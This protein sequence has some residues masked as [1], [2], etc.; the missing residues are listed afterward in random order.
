MT[1]IEMRWGR[2]SGAGCGVCTLFCC[3]SSTTASVD[4]R[5]ISV[6]IPHGFVVTIS[7]NRWS[8]IVGYDSLV[9][10]KF[11]RRSRNFGFGVYTTGSWKERDTIFRLT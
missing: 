5:K 8:Q 3:W 7:D 4:V 2:H 9:L 11:K 1:I 6:H 10:I